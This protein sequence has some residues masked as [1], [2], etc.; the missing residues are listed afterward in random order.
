MMGQV[1]DEVLEAGSVGSHV[2]VVTA[3]DQCGGGGQPHGGE[4]ESI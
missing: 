3:V 2:G 4:R 1:R